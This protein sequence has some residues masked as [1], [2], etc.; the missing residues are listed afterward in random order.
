VVLNAFSL[1][2]SMQEA[3][4]VADIVLS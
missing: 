3:S 2:A 1:F 4:A